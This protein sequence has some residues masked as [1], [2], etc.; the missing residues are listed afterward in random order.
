MPTPSKA[1]KRKREV[2]DIQKVMSFAEGRR[3][4]RRLLSKGGL[5]MSVFRDRPL[6]TPEQRVVFNGAQRDFAQWLHDEVL[7]CAP[8]SFELM[9]SDAR[10][11]YVLDRIGTVEPMKET[12][13]ESGDA[14]AD[15]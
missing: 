1:E 8:Q 3:F 10:A 15:A 14:E 6:L 9:N 12:M 11:Q 4:I 13:E 7:V 5:Y 2:E